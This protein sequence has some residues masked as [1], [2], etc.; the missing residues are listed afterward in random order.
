MLVL[1]SSCS[2]LNAQDSISKTMHQ[3]NFIWTTPV[4]KNTTINGVGLGLL[5]AV[6]WMKAD[7]LVVN[8]LNVDVSFFGVFGV[9]YAL[10]GSMA[11]PFNKNEKTQSGG[12]DLSTVKIYTD[13]SSEIQ[14]I[15]RGISLSFGGIVRDTKIAGVTLNGGISYAQEVEGF[16]ITG[17]MNLHYRFKGVMMAGLRNKVTT[18]KGM[19]IGL[20][21]N[22]KQGQVFQIGLLNRIGKRIWPVCNFSFRKKA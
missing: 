10:F 1:S 15:I 18:G 2:A 3:R 14:T 12:E 17:V 13:S 7:L 9:Y 22:C 4:K 19:Q 8:G 5:E 20:F 21:N 16:E 6:P 11:A